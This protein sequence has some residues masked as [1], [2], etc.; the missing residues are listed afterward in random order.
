[1]DGE[2]T[3]GGRTRARRRQRRKKDFSLSQGSGFHL[4]IS[5]LEDGMRTTFWRLSV[6][7]INDKEKKE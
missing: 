3:C 1:M 2:R 5:S 4:F 6:E 7:K